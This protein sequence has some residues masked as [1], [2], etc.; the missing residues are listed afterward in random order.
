MKKRITLIATAIMLASISCWAQHGVKETYRINLGEATKLIKSYLK[1]PLLPNKKQQTVGGI[2]PTSTFKLGDDTPGKKAGILLW[3][4]YDGTK[5]FVALD[6]I[7]HYD[8]NNTPKAQ[9]IKSDFLPIS[10]ALFYLTD[11]DD[12]IKNDILGTPRTTEVSYKSKEQIQKYNEMFLAL[13][14]TAG[15]PYCNYGYSCFANN[16]P[17]H[18]A[19]FLALSDNGFVRYYFGYDENEMSNNRIRV[20]LVACDK[21]GNKIKPKKQE[22]DPSLVETSWPPPPSKKKTK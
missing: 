9:D 22:Q 8:E 14:D 16:E 20:I 13:K 4:C 2:L 19:A 15:R 11:N 1:Q 6:K 12:V 18:Y 17:Q 5:I 3:F 10:D 21:N 7:D